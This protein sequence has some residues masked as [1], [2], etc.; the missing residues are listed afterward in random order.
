MTQKY[1]GKLDQSGFSLLKES[2]SP[3]DGLVGHVS[4]SSCLA[5]EH[6]LTNEPVIDQIHGELG[7]SL[8]RGAL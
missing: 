5:G 2:V 6:L 4:K 7:H 8:A 3:F 1:Q